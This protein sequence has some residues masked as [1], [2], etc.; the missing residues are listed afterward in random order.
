MNI[1]KFR[2]VLLLVFVLVFCSAGFTLPQLGLASNQ[3]P[4]QVKILLGFKERYG[5]DNKLHYGIDVYAEKGAELYA[6]AEGSISFVGRVPGSAGLNVTALTITTEAGHQVS[7]NPFATT[8]VKL[9]DAVKK[10]QVL[11]TLS[12]VGDPSSLASHFHLSLR[13]RGVYKDPTHLLMET[14]STSGVG[15]EGSDT[16]IVAT[17]PPVGKAPAN[18]S[19]SP[20]SSAAVQ[21]QA[22]TQKSG[23]RT[24]QSN[25]QNAAVAKEKSPSTAL[26]SFAQVAPDGEQGQV[27]R[28]VGGSKDLA[29]S[30]VEAEA[31]D[32]A[33]FEEG[34]SNVDSTWAH[35]LIGIS[36]SGDKAVYS[37]AGQA[38][39]LAKLK[40]ETIFQFGQTSEVGLRAELSNWLAGMSQMQLTLGLF[41]FV[42]LASCTGVG[43]WRIVQLTGLD[44]S[45]LDFRESLIHS[46]KIKERK[47]DS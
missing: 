40:K 45:L 10:G 44:L 12:D 20:S 32:T 1:R 37:E 33:S 18:P 6:P 41:T 13:E 4:P 9:G 43:V 34:A 19:T 28:A 23:S 14:I 36:L 42:M 17:T 47:A 3:L 8:R 46:L 27:N 25:A 15:K 5:A 24:G 29:I 26:S 7:I 39:P 30:D 2:S 31:L 21:T 16:A 22:Q 35:K 38:S 11:G